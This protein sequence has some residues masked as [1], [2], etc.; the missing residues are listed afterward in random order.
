MYVDNVGYGDLGCYGNPDVITPRIDRL[1]REGA[2]CLDFQVVTT[3]CT[4][5]RGA[6]LTGRHPFRNGLS[7]QLSAAENRSG[8]GLPHGERIIPEFLRSV[9]YATGC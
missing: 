2:R 3:S 9:G 1:A 7:H 8:I 5:S 4:P 6:L